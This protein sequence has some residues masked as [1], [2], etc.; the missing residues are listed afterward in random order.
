MEVS[1]VSDIDVSNSQ[2]FGDSPSNLPTKVDKTET[3]YEENR[4]YFRSGFS[5]DLTDV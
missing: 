2:I 5:F 1:K 3:N 4:V